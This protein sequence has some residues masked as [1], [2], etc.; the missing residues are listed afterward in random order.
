MT[1]QAFPTLNGEAQSWANCSATIQVYE[2]ASIELPDLT[3]IKWDAPV[4]RG[5]QRS[6]NG[7]IKKTTR[8]QSTP[9]ASI[10][11]YADQE[12]ILIEGLIDAA[13]ALGFVENGIAKYGMVPFDLVV[14]HT[15]LGGVGIQKTEVLGCKLAGNKGEFAEG[16]DPDK[17]E[18][19]L[20]ILDVVRT[21]N[22]KR[23]SIL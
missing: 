21:I 15:P 23:G 8:G 4:D 5:V 11:M 12:K 17:T 2:G 19:P 22:G 16:V 6:M 3:A 14:Q 20:S 1:E 7:K 13:I 9:V 10:E 18:L